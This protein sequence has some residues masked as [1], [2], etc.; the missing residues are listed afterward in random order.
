MALTR[1]RTV[2]TG[3]PGTPWYSNMFFDIE[4]GE[5]QLAADAVGA[6]W[7]DVASLMNNN[8]D[9]EVED[10]VTV[11]NPE[12]GEPV[13]VGSVTGDSGSGTGSGNMLARAT[14]AYI[15]W[16][17]GTWLGGRQIRGRTFLPG[18]VVGCSDGQGQVQPGV[19]LEIA[20][21]AAALLETPG[22]PTL[23]VYSRKNGQS[24]PVI[25]GQASNQFAVLRSR[26]D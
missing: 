16:N 3:V 13:G 26:R 7:T 12:N 25:S 17:T 18:L 10:S 23:N 8:V 19:V 22:N 21:A 2:F 24:L 9:W 1:V 6:F 14:Q 15:I 5:I 20:T 4:L 11:L